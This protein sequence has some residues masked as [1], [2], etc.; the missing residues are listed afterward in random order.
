MEENDILFVSYCWNSLYILKILKFV[1]SQEVLIEY[2]L[3]FGVN[4]YRKYYYGTEIVFV[5][6]ILKK[7]HFF[8]DKFIFLYY[9]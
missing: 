2:D 1:I 7:I 5:K 8:I 9:T 6:W 4:G 3:N